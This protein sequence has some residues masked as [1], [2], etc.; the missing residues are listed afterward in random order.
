MILDFGFWILD[1]GF[2]IFDFRFS[3]EECMG[4]RIFCLAPIA[5]LL[6][7]NFPVEAQPPAKVHRIGFLAGGSLATYT[8]LIEALRQNLR[9]LGYIEDR[10]IAIEY[11]ASEGRKTA[12]LN[13]RWNSCVSRFTLS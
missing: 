9:E 6:M 3:I 8:A 4:N 12:F 5:L 1:F 11:R 10:N 2:W 13:S 7:F